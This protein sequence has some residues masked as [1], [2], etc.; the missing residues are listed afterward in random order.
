ME[1]PVINNNSDDNSDDDDEEPEEPVIDK[2]PDKEMEAEVPVIDKPPTD[3]IEEDDHVSNVSNHPSDNEMVVE[4]PVKVPIDN[5]KEGLAPIK[6]TDEI[7]KIPTELV[8]ET[9]K[10]PSN[11]TDVAVGLLNGNNPKTTP[12]SVRREIYLNIPL[13][14]SHNGTEPPSERNSSQKELSP[15]GSNTF[16]LGNFSDRTPHTSP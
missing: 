15:L 3:D 2:P 16:R 7:P 4:D 1:A 14:D 11:K 12:R 10:S 5:M 6:P 13:P 8:I 9:P